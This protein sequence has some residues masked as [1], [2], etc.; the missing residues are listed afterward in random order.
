M[1]GL[2]GHT[3]IVGYMHIALMGNWKEIVLEQFERL[4]QSGLLEI[5][6]KIEVTVVG[7]F[8]RFEPELLPDRR[9]R[10]HFSGP[11]DQFE[12]PSLEKMRQDSA[13]GN[14]LVWYIHT[15]GVKYKEFGMHFHE[16]K[17]LPYEGMID[18]RKYMEFFAIDMFKDCIRVLKKY[19][20]CG[21]DYKAYPFP[22]FSGNFWWARMDHIRQLPSLEALK[23]RP[24]FFAHCPELPLSERHKA[25]FWLFMKEHTRHKCLHQS[26]TNFYLKRFPESQYN[27]KSFWVRLFKS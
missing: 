12:F 14:G 4:K 8:S 16:G 24:N 21:V 18:W 7:D 3:R 13:E 20:C 22:H 25:E 17:Q 19:D 9:F 6:E 1:K 26:K 2:K 23:A 15:K 5:T 10:I 11:L 27:K